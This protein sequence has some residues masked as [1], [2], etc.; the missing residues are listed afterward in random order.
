MNT[1]PIV[2]RVLE[3]LDR[4]VGPGRTPADAGP[5][6][7]LLEEGFWLDSVGLI[8]TVLTCEEAFRVSL[9]RE[10]DLA[11]TGLVTVGGLAAAIRRKLGD[12]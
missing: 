7:P 6:T 1:D 12:D 9:D 3:I 2:A 8:E 4:I 10:T 11:G 5:A